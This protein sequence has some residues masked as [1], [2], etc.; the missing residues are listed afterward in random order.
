MD[1]IPDA[2]VDTCVTSPPYFGLR[3]YDHA[4]QI[5]REETFDE[6][7]A[8]MVRV[9]R[10]VRRTLRPNGTLW[11]NLGDTYY[12]GP[13]KKS[14]S[15]SRAMKAKDQMLVPHTIAMALR[16]DGWWLRDTIV[17]AKTNA[18]P[19]PIRDR[20][21]PAHEYVFLL[22]KSPRY[23][24]DYQAAMVKSRSDHTAPEDIP[25][26]NLFGSDLPNVPVLQLKVTSLD[27]L[28]TRNLD[29]RKT[30]GEGVGKESHRTG[31]R[32]A[33]NLSAAYKN[34]DWAS[35]GANPRSVWSISPARY[36]GKHFATMPEELARRCIVTGSPPGGVVLDP[37]SG[38][39]T[40]L[41]V[42]LG[43]GRSFV[44]YEINPEY[45]AMIQDRL[46]IFSPFKKDM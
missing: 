5:G 37:F 6:Y 29:L 24:Y 44:G 34:V 27:D 33:K 16:D 11:L 26:E 9:F 43:T 31:L 14:G 45:C 36:F 20:T 35:I 2:S 21:T 15:E 22:S 12:Q 3:D 18:M 7:V 40:T 42:A 28:T 8:K 17:W 30:D 25:Q 32:T 23:Y 13:S 46:G 4:D 19:S 41:A 38:S 10:E 1:A 39:G